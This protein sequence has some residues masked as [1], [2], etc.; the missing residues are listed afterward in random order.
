MLNGAVDLG[1]GNDTLILANGANAVTVSNVETLTGGSANDTVTL[2]SALT[3]G[4]TVDLGAGADRLTLANAARHGATSPAPKQARGIL[5]VHRL[6]DPRGHGFAFVHSEIVWWVVERDGQISK[7]SA[8]EPSATQR[9]S[10]ATIAGSSTGVAGLPNRSLP[11]RCHHSHAGG[12][13]ARAAQLGISPRTFL[14]DARTATPAPQPAP[15]RGC[16]G[17]GRA[18]CRLATTMPRHLPALDTRRE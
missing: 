2:D 13:A 18:M 9:R 15:G 4:M 10:A 12:Y 14:A 11:G 6:G 3:I 17:Q 5:A 8:A 1:A 7:G 16:H